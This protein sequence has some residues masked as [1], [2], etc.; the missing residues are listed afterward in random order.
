MLT[1]KCKER[2]QMQELVCTGQVLLIFWPYRSFHVNSGLAY[3]KITMEDIAVRS[4]WK[5]LD[6]FE[7]SV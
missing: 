3:S 7:H 5:S 2:E 4:L 6:V 1:P